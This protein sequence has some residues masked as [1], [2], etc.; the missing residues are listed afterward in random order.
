MTRSQA[1]AALRRALLPAV[2]AAAVTMA[3]VVLILVNRAS[4]YQ[5]RVAVVATPVQGRDQALQSYGSVVSSV[6]PAIPE[7]AVS[8][9]VLDRVHQQVPDTTQA[10]LQ[11]SVA[12]ELVPASGVARVTVTGDSPAAATAVLRAVVDGIR[13][14]DLLAPVAT[15]RVLGNVD[16]PPTEVR[17]DPLLATG[18]G[19]LAAVLVALLTVAAVQ[20]ARPRLL[21]ISDVEQ[22]VKSTTPGSVPVVALSGHQGALDLL[23]TRVAAA[24]P[25]ATRVVPYAAGPADPDGLVDAVNKRLQQRASSRGRTSGDGVDHDGPR[26]GVRSAGASNGRPSEPRH[27]AQYVSATDPALVIVRLR[28]TS[29]DEL[30]AAVL[31]ADEAGHGVGVVVAQ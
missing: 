27:G 4:E 25:A 30:T 20:I 7:L 18:L 14:S 13:S 5:A 15:F 3:L 26:N 17:P 29:A 10:Q 11:Q 12:V 16:V 24:A 21:T 31:A 28:R 9:Q 6:L 22:V 8:S 1:L 2:L 19:A 23:V